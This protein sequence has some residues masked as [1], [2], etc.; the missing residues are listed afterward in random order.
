MVGLITI[1]PSIRPMRTAPTGPSHGI[2]E[3]DKR[4]RRADDRK[5]VGVILLVGRHDRRDDLDFGHVSLREQRPNR[6]VGQASRKDR[7]SRSVGPRA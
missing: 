2:G 3:I 4:G 7:V 1:L 6:P 5:D